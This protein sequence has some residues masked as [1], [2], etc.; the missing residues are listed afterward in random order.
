MSNTRA[1]TPQEWLFELSTRA[2]TPAKG[3]N[4]EIYKPPTLIKNPAFNSRKSE[5]IPD[6]T[7][8]QKNTTVSELQF[9]MD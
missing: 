6:L 2:K 5:P 8:T 4:V 9:V 3:K 7:N 1:K